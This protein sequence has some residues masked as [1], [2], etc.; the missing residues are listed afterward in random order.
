MERHA[1]GE[2]HGGFRKEI[3]LG[4]GRDT[5]RRRVEFFATHTPGRAFATGADRK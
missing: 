1:R 3:V 2:R 4:F 5:A